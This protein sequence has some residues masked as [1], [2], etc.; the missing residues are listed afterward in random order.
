MRRAGRRCGPARRGPCSGKRPR[1][2]VR[3]PKPDARRSQAVCKRRCT[4]CVGQGGQR[5]RHEVSFASDEFSSRPSSR[6]TCPGVEQRC[7]GGAGRPGRHRP[8]ARAAGSSNVTPSASRTRLQ[9]AARHGRRQLPTVSATAPRRGGVRPERLRCRRRRLRRQTASAGVTSGR[10]AASLQAQ[11]L[12]PGPPPATSP[13]GL[14]TLD[15][16]QLEQVPPARTGPCGRALP[17][18][19]RSGRASCSSGWSAGRGRRHP[20]VGRSRVIN[21]RRPLLP[22]SSMVAAARFVSSELM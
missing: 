11:Q 22:N 9:T 14:Q 6:R 8:T 18:G 19:D 15:R 2:V 5:L 13:R 16:H 10:R 17:P 4:L 1:A 12:R 3:A 21:Q 20:T 7:R